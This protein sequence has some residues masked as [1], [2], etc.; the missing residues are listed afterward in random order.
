MAKPP[1]NSLP[2]KVSGLNKNFKRHYSIY[3]RVDMIRSI[4]HRNLYF[5]FLLYHAY[6][7]LR[8]KNLK[9]SV[10]FFCK[11]FLNVLLTK[12]AII[13]TFF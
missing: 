10:E 8:H 6:I 5:I 12:V 1:E 7:T 9:K 11:A 3:L 13:L 2:V 4:N